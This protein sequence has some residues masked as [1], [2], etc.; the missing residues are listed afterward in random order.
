MLKFFVCSF[1]FVIL[2]YCVDILRLAIDVHC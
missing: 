2:F 1:K